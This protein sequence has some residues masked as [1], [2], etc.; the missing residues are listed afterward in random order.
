[1]A[2]KI[3]PELDARHPELS[4]AE[5]Q[6]IVQCFMRRAGRH[7]STIPYLGSFKAHG[8][9]KGRYQKYLKKARTDPKYRKKVKRD[10]S[11]TKEHLLF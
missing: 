11:L 2:V 4:M 10:L 8:N 5:K 6:W 7:T 1:M 3:S 9:K